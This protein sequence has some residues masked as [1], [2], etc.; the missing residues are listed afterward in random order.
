MFRPLGDFG[1]R[2]VSL[3]SETVTLA[4]SG[5]V[6]NNTYGAAVTTAYRSA[7]IAAENAFQ[8]RF[9]GAL[10]VNVDFELQPLSAGF[11]SQSSFPTVT[12]S[13]ASFVGALQ[14]HATTGD[15]MLAVASLPTSD[16]T[17]GL[18]I[19]LPPAEARLLGLSIFTPAID[20]TV[21]LNSK[22]GFTFGQDA[23]GAIE[24]ELSEGVFGRISSL[25]Q[26]ATWEPMDLFRF[27]AT[28]ARDYTGGADGV[29]VFFGVDAGHVTALALHNSI[30]ASGS[31]DGQD[32]ADWASSV[33]GDAFGL[34]GPSAPGTLS[35]TD[36]RVLDILGLTPRSAAGPTGAN[37]S[38]V[39]STGGG[40]TI[41]GL[42]GNDTIVAGGPAS[43]YLRGGDGDDSLL[44]GSG[45]D[46]INGNKGDDTIDGGSGGSDWLV[47][48]QGNDS[49]TAH[50]SGN[51]VYGNLGNDTLHGGS[52]RDVVRGGQG[53]D[54]ITA[55]SG[56]QFLSGDRG[57]DTIMAGAGHDT[58]HSS[59]DAGI[60][61]VLNYNTVLDVV[62]LDP[63]TTYT[64][65]QVGADTVI[66]MGAGNQVILVGVQ[67]STLPSGW[68]FE[69]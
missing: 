61:R 50:N 43:N 37:D 56:D 9:T 35:A 58:I 14:A 24:H 68:I 28:G 32:L 60:D 49:I 51:L 67:L 55:G 41:D 3:P 46:D 4:G 33:H 40:D 11:V 23:I 17:M 6:F 26:F 8:T 44:G 12:V 69:G 2:V 7:A 45:F 10:T 36:L 62:Q 5:L 65:S 54:S 27:T 38:L 29:T 39:G 53:D 52:G 63:G 20:D 25:G 64:V 18:G 15:D 31:N 21:L 34:Q 47:G 57:N 19:T 48:G 1:T 30:S 13:Y 59:Q 22:S 16:P 42:A 66:D